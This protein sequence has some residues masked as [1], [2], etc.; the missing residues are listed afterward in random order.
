MPSLPDPHSTAKQS[1]EKSHAFGYELWARHVSVRENFFEVGG[2]SLLA[3][4]LLSAIEKTTGKAILLGELFKDRQLKP[5]QRCNSS[6]TRFQKQAD[7]NSGGTR[8]PLFLLQG[9][10]EIATHLDSDQPFYTCLPHGEDGLRVPPTIAEIASDYIAAIRKVQPPGPYLI[11]GFS[12][13]GLVALEMAH[14]FKCLAKAWRY[15]Y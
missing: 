9:T 7:S 12:F 1:E 5:C 6:L 2:H 10:C 3:V 11:G 4:Q 14:Q 8:L 15:S 13:G